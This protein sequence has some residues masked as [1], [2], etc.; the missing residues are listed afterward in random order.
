MSFFVSAVRAYAA[1]DLVLHQ[2]NFSAVNETL[3]YCRGRCGHTA[4]EYLPCQEQRMHI[5]YKFLC[6]FPSPMA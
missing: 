5:M 4:Q 2:G 6:A 3:V 1:E